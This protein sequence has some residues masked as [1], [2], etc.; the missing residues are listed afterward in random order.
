MKL[1]AGGKRFFRDAPGSN[2]QPDRTRRIN[3]VARQYAKGT[4]KEQ[5]RAFFLIPAQYF[6]RRKGS[7]LQPPAFLQIIQDFFRPIRRVLR[8]NQLL[9]EVTEIH[10][11]RAFVRL[12]DQIGKKRN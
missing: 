3:F 4:V 9:V 11:L 10:L 1:Q 5:K 8:R 7:F 2:E 6:P 12:C